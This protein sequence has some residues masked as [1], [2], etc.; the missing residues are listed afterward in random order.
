MTVFRNLNECLSLV[1]LTPIRTAQSKT[2]PRTVT[3]AAPQIVI[4]GPSHG[5]DDHYLFVIPRTVQRSLYKGITIT[6]EE[7][8]KKK[9]LTVVAD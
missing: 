4:C 6:V 7:T 3:P 9:W 2:V 8:W 1:T 5:Y